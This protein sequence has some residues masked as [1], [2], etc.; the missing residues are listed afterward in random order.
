M[1]AQGLPRFAIYFA[2]PAD[3]ALYQ[4]GSPCVG[5]D[6]VSGEARAHPV[7]DGVT[8]ERWQHLAASPRIYGFHATLKPPFRLADGRTREEL[9]GALE[10]F[11]ATRTPVDA[12]PLRVS[13]VS[14]FIAM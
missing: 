14:N 9:V 13:R 5:R 3:S 8:A 10:A 7:V 1:N 2:P 6:A 4:F 11:A 12:S